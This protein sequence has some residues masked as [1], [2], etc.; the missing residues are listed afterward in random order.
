MTAAPSRDDASAFLM[1]QHPGVMNTR[2]QER[3]S[4][5]EW[6]EAVEV[7]NEG[8]SPLHVRDSSGPSAE[9]EELLRAGR[10]CT[11]GG[12][13]FGLLP[14]AER[15]AANDHVSGPNKIIGCLWATP[16]LKIHINFTVDASIPLL[17]EDYV[18]LYVRKIR[19]IDKT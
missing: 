9:A 4:G 3:N 8:L 19:P 11:E 6:A 17:G 7:T 15:D 13:E 12:V 14:S 18:T 2:I 16:S 10:H 5:T 1:E